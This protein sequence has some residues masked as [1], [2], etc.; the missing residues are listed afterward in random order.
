[1]GWLLNTHDRSPIMND[2]NC[3]PGFHS[4][5]LGKYHL[6][7]FNKSAGNFPARILFFLFLL[8]TTAIRPAVLAQSMNNDIMTLRVDTVDSNPVIRA[9]GATYD[10]MLPLHPSILPNEMPL[11]FPLDKNK[12]ANEGRL[13]LTENDVWGPRIDVRQIFRVGNMWCLFYGSRP[14]PGDQESE[15]GLTSSL[16]FSYDLIQW[17]DSPANPIV[18]ELAQNCQ[19]NR[20]RAEALHYDEEKKQWVMFIGG[21]GDNYIPGLRA[22]GVTYSK[23]LKN[24]TF[25]ENNPIVT[26]DTG[27]IRYWGAGEEV[28]RVYPIGVR[29]HNNKWYL[30]LQAG[31]PATCE[32]KAVYNA[33]VLVADSPDGPW[34]D[35]GLN[36]IISRGGEFNFVWKNASYLHLYVSNRS[37]HFTASALFHMNDKDKN[38]DK[39]F[40]EVKSQM[41]F[42]LGS[43]NILINV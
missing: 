34:R 42:R 8:M 43:C 25:G 40:Q 36:P 24:W 26:V 41:T 21:N 28:V 2:L 3:T 20:A 31:G 33:G 27:D 9:L 23:N 13:I 19:G 30:F 38:R 15:A 7:L 6:H 22:V 10:S 39:K 32:F 1:M 17:K 37:F 5:L 12:W 29:R 4:R 11:D 14:D 16:A 18:H 35:T